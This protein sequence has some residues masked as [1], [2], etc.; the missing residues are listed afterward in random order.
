[1]R[2]LKIN[3][4]RSVVTRIIVILHKMRA[5]RSDKIARVTS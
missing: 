5:F 1:M 4:M 3:I 2:S